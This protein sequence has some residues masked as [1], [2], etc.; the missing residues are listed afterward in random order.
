AKN[1]RAVA[2]LASFDEL[3]IGEAY[4][5]GDLDI[6][7][8]LIAALDLRSAFSDTHWLGHAYAT[9]VEPL[10]FGQVARDKK[11]IQS[12]YD[13]DPSFY[14][15][16]LD[17][18]AR[19][20]S[21]GYFERDDETLEAAIQRKLGTAFDAC[22][23]GP[24]ARVLDIGAGWGAFTQYAGRRGARVTSLTISAESQRYV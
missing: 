1:A 14:L 5:D 20:Y 4:L 9:Y 15:L 11:W 18:E 13:S 6:E 3:R 22:S 7:G 19:C 2:A 8:S 17:E 12:H 10:V 24:G 21:H 23:L 16:F